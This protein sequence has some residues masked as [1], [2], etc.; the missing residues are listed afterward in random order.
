[1]ANKSTQSPTI[2]QDI[3]VI[4]W[5]FYRVQLNTYMH[6]LHTA[7]PV[8]RRLEHPEL[9]EVQACLDRPKNPHISWGPTP[10]NSKLSTFSPFKPTW[11]LAYTAPEPSAGW[12]TVVVE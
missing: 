12:N 7:G 1:M 6:H 10:Q 9:Q 2:K 8:V 3:E 4:A 5:M 11:S